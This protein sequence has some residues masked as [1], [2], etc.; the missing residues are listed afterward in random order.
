MESLWAAPGARLEILDAHMK[1]FPCIGTAQT[2]V[3]AALALHQRLD[4]Q[5]EAIERIEVYMADLPFVRDQQEDIDRRFPK[6]REA[7]DHSFSF[8]P[9]VALVDGELTLKQFDNDRWHEPSLRNMMERVSLHVAPDLNQRAPDSMPCR[10]RVVLRDGSDLVAECLY[11]AGHS[12]PTGLDAE[13]V[14]EKFRSVSQPLL[15]SKICEQVI[16]AALALDDA[17]SVGRLM[18]LVAAPNVVK[19]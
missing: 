4:G 15:A 2:A 8:L 12:S 5:T 17:K 19:Q 7:A 16:D 11:P 9:A 3:Q 1:S 14:K 6:S 10:L 13:V 18:A